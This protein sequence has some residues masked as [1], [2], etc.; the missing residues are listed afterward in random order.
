M[1]RTAAFGP[2][3]MATIS[4][5]RHTHLNPGEASKTITIEVKSDSKQEADETFYLDLFGHRSNALFTK[6]RGIGTS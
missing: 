3:T 5:E 4:P 1:L 2:K 6:N